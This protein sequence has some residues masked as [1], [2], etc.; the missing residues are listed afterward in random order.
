MFER[1]ATALDSYI[2]VLEPDE[3]EAEWWAGA[4]SVLLDDDGTFY[5]AARMREGNSPRGKRG[6]ENRI[7]QS[8]DG[9]SFETINQLHRDDVGI[10]G[11]ERPSLVKDPTTGK[12]RLYSCSGLD[13]NWG[14]IKFADADHPS[15]I[16]PKS[17]E[18]VLQPEIE[19]DDR[20]GFIQV[21]GYKDPFVFHD[22]SCW[23]MLV[24]GYDRIERPY[25]FTSDDGV[26]WA[27]GSRNADRTLAGDLRR[28]ALQ[29]PIME[30]D[31][32]HNVFTRP[33]CV[34]PMTIGYML[35]Y[36]GS[37]VH[38]RDPSYNIA[39]GL[40][41]TPDLE[42]YVDLTPDAPLLMSTTP[43]DYHTWRYSHWLL[44]GDKVHVYF[45]A[46]RPNNSNEIRLATF[47]AEW[48][49]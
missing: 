47:D 44:V 25:H 21:E 22:G 6:Y 28:S 26:A 1:I 12:Y 48:V 30:N 32:W 16:D 9:R 38:W 13:G 5:M 7:L 45:E 18:V 49:R 14:I 24:I 43:G 46:S 34:L 11:F 10:P 3:N 41:Y 40:A 17:W 33:A 39:T 35:V 27:T 15:E 29:E 4:P 8:A 31:G 23:H 2:T 19:R 42:T 36:E 20:L 37:S